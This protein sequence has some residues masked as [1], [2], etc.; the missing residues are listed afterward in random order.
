MPNHSLLLLFDALPLPFAAGGFCAIS[1]EIKDGRSGIRAKFSLEKLAMES[2][3]RRYGDV[4]MAADFAHNDKSKILT[5]FSLFVRG[6]ARALS[7]AA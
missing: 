2:S 7:M 1:T 4:A 3:V 5:L 6:R